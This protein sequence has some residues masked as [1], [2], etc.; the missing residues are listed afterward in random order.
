MPHDAKGNLL[1]VGDK[2]NILATI[3]NICEGQDYCNCS[4]DFDYLMPPDNT[5]TTIAQ[6]N[7]RQTE[8]K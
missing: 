3:K 4:V 2:V 6:I 7:T 1:V 5:I 8:K